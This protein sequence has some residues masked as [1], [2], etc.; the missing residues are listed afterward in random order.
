MKTYDNSRKVAIGLFKIVRLNESLKLIK[1]FL[2][3]NIVR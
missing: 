3:L 1:I 2:F